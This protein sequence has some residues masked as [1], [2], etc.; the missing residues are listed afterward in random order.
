MALGR[1]TRRSGRW[2][3]QLAGQLHRLWQLLLKG[4]DEVRA[5]PDPLVAAK[6]ALLRVQHAADMPDPARWR[7]SWKRSR[8]VGPSLLRRA[9]LLHLHLLRRKR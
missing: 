6:M 4:H 8:R 2:A 5:A 9:M 1:G 7:R 3:G